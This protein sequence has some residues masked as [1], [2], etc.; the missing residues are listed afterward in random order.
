VLNAVKAFAHDID[1][2]APQGFDVYSPLLHAL[3]AELQR[4]FAATALLVVIRNIAVRAVAVV[5][6]RIRQVDESI[7]QA[8]AVC[9]VSAQ[10]TSA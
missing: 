6:A 9:A 7:A 2:A 10:H 1:N 5:D 8:S 3:K 4:N